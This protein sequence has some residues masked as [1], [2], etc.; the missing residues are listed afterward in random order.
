MAK[1]TTPQIDFCGVVL[2][3]ASKNREKRKNI[4]ILHKDLDII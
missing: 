3:S 2:C 1:F 4:V